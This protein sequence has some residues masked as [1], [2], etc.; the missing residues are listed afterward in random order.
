MDDDSR[1]RRFVFRTPFEHRPPTLEE[2]LS[3][4]WPE[5]TDSGR[6]RALEQGRVEV[7]GRIARRADL[8]P[9]PGSRIVA[10]VEPE[11]EEYD[12]RE[13]TSLERAE[14]WVVADKPVGMPGRLDPDDPM[15]PIFFLADRLG[16]DRDTFTPVWPM[17]TRAGGPW[18][19]AQTPADASDLRRRWERG[20]LMTT[21]LALVPRPEVAQGTLYTPS[22]HRVQYAT[23][24]NREQLAELQLTVEW[25]GDG[26][27]E[28][29]D[30]AEH[31]RETFA[32]EGTPVVGD[33]RYGGFMAPGALRLRLAALFDRET[34]LQYS[35]N[36]P[37]GW[38]PDDPTVPPEPDEPETDV[39]TTI[40]DLDL[41][42]W[43]VQSD[44]LGRI[45]RAEHPWIRPT[46][47][48]GRHDQLRPGTLV[49]VRGTNDVYGPVAILDN[50]PDVA[51]RIWSRSPLDAV[52]FEETVELRA[53]EALAARAPLI[54]NV[55]ETDLFR[56]VHGEADGL[57]GIAVDRVGPVLRAH[58]RG[59]AAYAFREVLYDVLLGYDPSRMILE[60]EP[61]KDT[62][63]G[64]RVVHSGGSYLDSERCLVVREAGLRYRADPWSG[65]LGVDPSHRSTRDAVR[66]VA[67]PD[68]EWL[69]ATTPAAL[70]PIPLVDAGCERVRV[71]TDDASPELRDLLELND[72]PETPLEPRPPASLLESLVSDDSD[73]V[74]Y[75]GAC[76]DLDVGASL[77]DA[78]PAE[79]RQQVAGAV[80]ERLRDGGTALVISQARPDRRD[81]GEIL[82]DAVADRE[83]TL[84]E[85]ATVEPPPD[86]PKLENFPEGTPYTAVRAR[87]SRT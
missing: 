34:E 65:R 60:V 84:A 19:F 3:R 72:L 17:P 15:H 36:A 52:E 39:P 59:A 21:W 32:D 51:A 13:A 45:R 35:W 87:I 56:L 55:A 2:L 48:A 5:G 14:Q 18:L 6:E 22:G 82:A 86:F 10:E 62:G 20:D 47:V 58:I 76:V 40:D 44:A 41:P 43:R 78:E 69:V 63:R 38:F 53:E 81:A 42:E 54:R 85:R 30:F 77:L 74:T 75:N 29:F 27:P 16:I 9:E 12:A 4:A 33:R 7:E 46:D 64:A 61:G 31:L 37:E 26:R 68:E 11:F 1:T 28:S 49:R 57:P 79:A 23:T 83:M 71:A 8:E 25:D 70:L 67:G 66:E 80:C 50:R 24:T 73:P